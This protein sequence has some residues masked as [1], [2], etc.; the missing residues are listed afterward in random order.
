MV[1]LRH[2]HAKRFCVVF[3]NG[4]DPEKVTLRTLHGFANISNEGLLSVEHDDGAFAVPPSCYRMVLPS[5]GTELLK[6]AE[7]Y[8]FCKV[9]GFD[10]I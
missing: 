9:S 7:Y 2:I 3:V 10:E 8:V 4:D 6:D 5:D 1:D